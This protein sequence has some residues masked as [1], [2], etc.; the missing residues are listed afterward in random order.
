MA[1]QCPARAASSNQRAASAASRRP[2]ASTPKRYAASTS[3]ARPSPRYQ[4]TRPLSASS[5]G[6]AQMMRET[7]S[8]P[9]SSDTPWK[10]SQACTAASPGSSNGANCL[11]LA[12]GPG[13]TKRPLPGLGER[14]TT[15]VAAAWWSKCRA[16]SDR[17]EGTYLRTSTSAAVSAGSAK[18]SLMYGSTRSSTAASTARLSASSPPPTHRPRDFSTT[19]GVCTGFLEPSSSGSKTVP[20]VA[21][22][23]SETSSGR[24]RPRST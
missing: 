11:E 12:P 20:S 4:E 8:W 16:C 17:S 13:C 5:R 19:T 18:A 23:T 22:R 24:R 14:S 6:F 3:P 2:S 7:R 1:I 15:Q 9:A 10:A 21:R